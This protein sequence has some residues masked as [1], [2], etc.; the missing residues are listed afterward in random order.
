MTTKKF[1]SACWLVLVALYALGLGGCALFSQA[2]HT[3]YVDGERRDSSSATNHLGVEAMIDK[4]FIQRTAVVNGETVIYYVD[5]SDPGKVYTMVRNKDCDGSSCYED[6]YFTQ[7]GE[8]LRQQ[9][10][11][12]EAARP[13]PAAK[14][15]PPELPG[16][17][18]DPRI[19]VPTLPPV[20]LPQN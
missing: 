20:P 2:S 6:R 1:R 17:L 3:I 11:D 10:L 18:P 7:P 5:R 8:P 16:L 19:T 15:S 14:S 9:L 4:W 12:I 13:V